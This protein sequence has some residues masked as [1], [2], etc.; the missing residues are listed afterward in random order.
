MTTYIYT[1]KRGPDRTVRGELEAESLDVAVARMDALGLIPVQVTEKT[2][3]R[4]SRVRRGA[5]TR[6]VRRAQVTVLTRQLAS[7]LRAGVPVLR[8]LR[9]AGE[10][11]ESPAVRAVLD[12]IAAAIRDGMML[13]EAMGRHPALF[14]PLYL[15]MVQAGEAA[16]SLD[17]SFLRMAET[18]EMEE[19]MRRKVQAALAYPALIL[20][21]GLATV[22][23][24]VAFFLPR[25]ASLF[26]SYRQLPWPTR[27]LMSSSGFL[28]HAWPWLTA[29][30]AAAALAGRRARASPRVRASL[31]RGV[32]KIPLIAGMVRDR[33]VGRF[34]RTLGQLI[35]AGVPI[36]RC[37]ALSGGVMRNS[38]LRAD[39]ERVRR[40]VMDEG[41]SMSEALRRYSGLPGFLASMLAVGEESGRVEQSLDE[42]AVFYEKRLEQATRVTGSLVE[43]LLVLAVG[44]VVGGIVAAMLLPVFSLSASLR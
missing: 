15:S 34:A 41:M 10:Q 37:L 26:E 40:A 39:V 16:G 17:A 42:A 5:G 33:E 38:V 8:A 1:A 23:V 35:R 25:I 36:E 19:D 30:L 3:Q 18:R 6:G 14:P 24:L 29:V 22:V 43:P 32:L 9:T 27:L 21:T 44:A 13:S 4:E 20:A 28:S 2:A 11:S 12:D 7:L 31:D